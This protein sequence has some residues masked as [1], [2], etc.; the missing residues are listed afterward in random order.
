MKDGRSTGRSTG[1]SA[2]GQR[3]HGSELCGLE[4][5]HPVRKLFPEEAQRR[6]FRRALVAPLY[7]PL[8]EL[9]SLK[10]ILNTLPKRADGAQTL[11]EGVRACKDYGNQLFGR[12]QWAD[13][14]ACYRKAII[15]RNEASATPPKT[16]KDEKALSME[17]AAVCSNMA[18]CCLKLKDHHEAVVAADSGLKHLGKCSQE[19]Q[20]GALAR[21]IWSRKAEGHEVLGQ[22]DE[23]E[24]AM[25]QVPK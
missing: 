8:V 24:K 9:A 7:P 16:A 6:H 25:R 22:L 10:G 13:A 15:L 18:L 5:E 20:T 4:R 2:A 21:K 19:H 12:Q 11:L 23:A 14:M 3:E 1:V 17:L